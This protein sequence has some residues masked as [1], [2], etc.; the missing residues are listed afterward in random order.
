ME[1]HK[2]RFVVR[3]MFLLVLVAA[4]GCIGDFDLGGLVPPYKDVVVRWGHTATLL[5]DGRVLIVG[6]SGMSVT[7]GAEIYDPVSG[8]VAAAG[9]EAEANNSRIWHWATRLSDGRVFVVGGQYFG[10]GVDEVPPTLVYDPQT[11][12]WA[13]A[14][15]PSGEVLGWGDGTALIP[16]DD[17]RVV[18]IVRLGSQVYDPNTG[19]W[20]PIAPLLRHRTLSTVTKLQDGRVL[21]V[22]GRDK[23]GDLVTEVDVYDP[24]QNSWSVTSAA[25]GPRNGH[26]AVLLD[27]GK[28]LVVGGDANAEI[29]EPTTGEWSFVPA[30]FFDDESPTATI[31]LQD[32]RIMVIGKRVF[33]SVG[34]AIVGESETL[35]EEQRAPVVLYDPVATAWKITESV[36]I[37]QWHFSSVLLADG[38]VL[39][40]GG[41]FSVPLGASGEVSW[42]NIYDPATATWTP[43]G[44]TF[45]YE[46]CFSD[47]SQ[48]RAAKSDS[49]TELTKRRILDHPCR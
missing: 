34:T 28:V 1:G 2:L 10:L 27:D 13:K 6:G 16:L 44:K 30:S 48:R 22:G 43:A 3:S 25:R 7:S 20:S 33:D 46:Y 40:V 9:L 19:H 32:G 42:G 21:V 24:R 36:P 29:Y 15:S 14:E 31:L 39:L 26:G 41:E 4:S 35:P 38:R 23:N 8:H 11:N 37:A 47:E 18:L 17:G 5:A 49:L 12:I 45:T